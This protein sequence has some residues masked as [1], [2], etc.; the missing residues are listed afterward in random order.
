MI[1]SGALPNVALRKPPI[2]RPG[3]V[4]GMLG[5]LADQPGERDQRDRREHEEQG[6]ARR[7]KT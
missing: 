7:R 5:R 2:A 1:S 3:V 4:G 6:V